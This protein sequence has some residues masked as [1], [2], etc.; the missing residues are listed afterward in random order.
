MKNCKPMSMKP[1]KATKVG[2]KGGAAKG[3]KKK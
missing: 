3:G 2:Y 1:G